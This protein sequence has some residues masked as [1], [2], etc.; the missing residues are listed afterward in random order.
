[1]SSLSHVRFHLMIFFFILAKKEQWKEYFFFIFEILKKGFCRKK[2]SKKNWSCTE[3]KPLFKISKMKKKITPFIALLL[4]KWKKNLSNKH[5][6]KWTNSR[7]RNGVVPETMYG[8]SRCY[9]TLPYILPYLTL[10]LTLPYLT[11]CLTLHYL[12]P[13]LTLHFALL[14]LTSYLYLPHVCIT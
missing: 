1:M 7:A 8:M 5:W 14:Y 6:E 3:G 9:L 12:L 11:F 13:Y 2:K 4:P 10:H